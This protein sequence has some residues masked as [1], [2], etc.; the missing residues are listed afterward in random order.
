MSQ[1]PQGVPA[2]QRPPRPAGAPM[3]QRPQGVPGAAP[4]QQRPARPQQPGALRGEEPRFAQKRGFEQGEAD[5]PQAKPLQR[6]RYD[7]EDEEEYETQE[8]R[9]GGFL[10][11][12]LIVLLVIGAL[13]AG[14]CLPKWENMDNGVAKA[15]GAIKSQ[16]VGLFEGIFPAEDPIKAFT[17]TPAGT[18]APTELRFDIRTATSVKSVRILDKMGQSVLEKTITDEASLS[19]DV[20]LNSNETIW[21]LR[22]QLEDEYMGLFTVQPMKK[23]GTWDDG[24]SLTTPVAIAA[25]AVVEPPVQGF[26]VSQTTGTVPMDLTLMVITSKDVVG[27]SINNDYGDSL[28]S[29]DA[30][31]VSGA[32]GTVTDSQAGR[33]WNLLFSAE[34]A[35]S[36]K[37]T[38]SYQTEQDPTFVPS[39]Y[40]QAINLTAAAETPSPLPPST[41]PDENGA[42]EDAGSVAMQESEEP[43]STPAPTT[44]A[45]PSPTPAPTPSPTPA[46]TALPKQTASSTDTTSP[47][48]IKLSSKIY[49]E[50]KTVSSYS[51]TRTIS[52]PDPYN[53]AIWEGGVFTF[54]GGS[55]RQ[56]ASFGTVEV[57]KKKLEQV[58][59][60]PV[61]SFKTKSKTLYGVGWPG[62]PAIVK[63]YIEARGMMN[64]TDEK[65]ETSALKEVILAAQDGKIYFLDLSDGTVTRDPIDVGVPMGSSVSVATDGTPMLAVGQSHSILANKTLDMGLRVYS[66]IN[67]KQL[68]F[69]DGRE[70]PKQNSDAAISGSPIFDKQSGSMIFGSK[71]GLLYT[72]D[73]GSTDEV[74]VFDHVAGTI[75]LK[76]TIQRYASTSGKEKKTDTGIDNSVAMYGSYAYFA[77]EYGILQ[78]VDVNTMQAVWAVSVDDA[79]SATI[80]LDYEDDGS[81]ALYTGNMIDRTGKKGV[82]TIRR[83]NALTGETVWS[84]AVEGLTYDTKYEIGCKASPVVGKNSIDNLVVFTVSNGESGA[85]T[86]ALDKKTGKVKWQKNWTSYTYSSPVAVYNEAG[87]AWLVQGENSGALN[88]LNAANGEVLDTMQLDGEIVGSPAV[89]RDMLV[90]GTGN[91]E[92]SKIY[93]IQIQ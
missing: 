16:I 84:Y 65:K 89:Y 20:V 22:Y 14:I 50:L 18:Q 8:R 61:G 51:R 13:L 7:F 3:P 88:L 5:L 27:V 29:M 32:V 23:D 10:I 69:I 53:Y 25:P 54:R 2:G 44:T 60:V 36:G 34:T 78:C 46:P 37:Y 15:V 48:A 52:I 24:L 58:W 42:D 77:D 75:K 17:C 30:A 57:E 12:L 6:P 33:I 28:V 74:S 92:N 90:I 56:N 83:L 19:Q 70:K 68:L 38:V 55:F 47:S 64:L 63:W 9:K 73:F 41:L 66:L 72:V 43:K 45:T 11:P 81:V 71:N 21:T 59:N 26:T 35:Y 93:G 86:L 80:A 49:S 1:R 40:S 79:T 4:V 76:E 39:E 67:G 82:C 31:D 85:M 62:Q 91:T 87:D